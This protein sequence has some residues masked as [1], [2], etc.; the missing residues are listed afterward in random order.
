LHRMVAHRPEVRPATGRD[1][2]VRH[3]ALGAAVRQVQEAVFG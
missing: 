2:A 1:H 3:G